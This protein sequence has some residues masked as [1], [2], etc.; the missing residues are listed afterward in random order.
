LNFRLAL[1][2]HHVMRV[3]AIQLEPG[4]D[5]AAN[6]AAARQEIG[7]ALSA[8][9]RPALVSL[10]EMWTC[11]GADR[12]TKLAQS[13]V[14]PRPGEP[15]APG[16]AYGF[17]S[18]TARAAGITLHG[19]SIGEREGDVL[20]NTTLVF[21]PDGQERARYRKIHLFDIV[22][23]NG[24]GY[25][26]SSMFGAGDRIVTCMADGLT[27][28]L[29][30]CYDLRFPELY[31]ALRRAGADVIFVPSAFT[32]ETGRDHWEVLLRARAIETQCY[33]VAA[34]TVGTHYDAAGRPRET[35]GHS[36]ICDPW[37]HVMAC[38]PQGRGAIDAE[39]DPGR[40]AKLRDAMPVLAHRRL[41]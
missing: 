12:A 24:A 11:L 3:I 23:P 29:T 36:L 40:I 10:P 27:L 14:L 19:G 39:L 5:K 38:R 22:T 15:C 8:T 34:A 32:V 2:L 18:E 31:L 7:A 9:P 20:F 25:R 33:V 28:G 35:Y 1:V 30:I 16:S 4:A 6:I 21:G 37:G 13:E 41:G 26:E 17:L